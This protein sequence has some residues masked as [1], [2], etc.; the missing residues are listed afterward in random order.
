MSRA[1]AGRFSAGASFVI[2]A[3]FNGVWE[4]LEPTAKLYVIYEPA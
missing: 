4:V 3:G 1:A 2:P